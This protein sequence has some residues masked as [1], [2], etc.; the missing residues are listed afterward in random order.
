MQG[1]LQFFFLY[2]ETRRCNNWLCLQGAVSLPWGQIFDARDKRR[3]GFGAQTT[4]NW[5][6]WQSSAPK[7]KALNGVKSQG[8]KNRGCGLSLPEVTI[9]Q[10]LLPSDWIQIWPERGHVWLSAVHWT[11]A[12]ELK[13]EILETT[14]GNDRPGAEANS[15]GGL[16]SCGGGL[17]FWHASCTFRMLV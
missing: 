17:V 7:T 11:R 16:G 3:I 4:R 5:P 1:Y 8:S 9:W 15:N 10:H 14:R 13:M 2:T 6:D 12:A